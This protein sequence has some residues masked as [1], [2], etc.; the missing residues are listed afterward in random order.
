MAPGG[1]CQVLKLGL[2]E[3]QQ[4]WEWQRGLVRARLQGLIPD[5]LLLLEHPPT[6]TIGRRGERG[7][8]LVPE[9]ELRAL[10]AGVYH[11]DRGGD[12]TFHG[13]GQLVGY[14]ILH[15]QG[16]L[17]DVHAYLRALE[18]VLIAT[19]ADYGIAAGRLPGLTGVW[20]GEEKI[21]AIG[22][23]ISR[24]VTSH[25]FALN[26][27]TDLRYFGYIHPCGLRDKGVTS[28]AS[29]LG[30]PVDMEGVAQRLIQRFGERFALEMST[31]F[32]GI[33][34][35]RPVGYRPALPC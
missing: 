10:G 34:K 31:S 15:L 14:P 20:V 22:V 18:D 32:E 17:R 11:V 33:K 26:V 21:G 30:A 25:G 7:N 5:L 29:L 19:L 28:M 13:P 2:V 3:Y 24:W 12:V 8:I 23:R 9:E 35:G 4:A 16:P 1:F 27:N 6:Y